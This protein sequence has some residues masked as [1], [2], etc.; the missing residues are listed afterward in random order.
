M[1]AKL[2]NCSR[3]TILVLG[4]LFAMF[5][6]GCEEENPALQSAISGGTVEPFDRDGQEYLFK[7]PEGCV[8]VRFEVSYWMPSL[9]SGKAGPEP[10]FWESFYLSKWEVER[11]G[12]EIEKLEVTV[13]E[14]EKELAR[15][16]KVIALVVPERYESWYNQAYDL[17]MFDDIKMRYES[18][19]VPIRYREPY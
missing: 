17:D 2:P 5:F 19:D 16:E 14:A 4:V 8:P 3:Y 6:A 18:S 7:L 12:I 9:G 1:R 15:D 10:S 11:R 13:D